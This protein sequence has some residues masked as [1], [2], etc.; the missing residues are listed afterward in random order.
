MAGPS[1][2]DIGVSMRRW[3]RQVSDGSKLS[4]QLFS[5]GSGRMVGALAVAA[6]Y[7]IAAHRLSVTEYATFALLQALAGM[8]LVGTDLGTTTMLAD[9][10]AHDRRR[11]RCALRRVIGMRLPLVAPVWLVVAGGLLV[12]A[13]GS[14]ASTIE[15]AALFLPVMVSSVV[16]SSAEGVLRALGRAWV[17]GVET[18]VLRLV[19]LV[20]S[21]IWLQHG[22]GL[23]ALVLAS[24]AVG[25]VGATGVTFAAAASAPSDG[26]PVPAGLV[27]LRRGR[28]LT[29]A[30]LVGTVYDR[31]DTWLLA[32]MAAPLA[33]STY[34]SAYRVFGAVLL[35][36]NAVAALSVPSTAGQQ[37]EALVRAGRRLV[38]WALVVTV[39]AAVVV[40]AEAPEV[41]RLLFGT[42][43]AGGAGAL[44]VLMLAVVPSAVGAAIVP[45]AVLLDGRRITTYF[46][47]SLVANVALDVAA[48]PF[49]GALGAAIGTATC[50]GAMSVAVWR[51]YRRAARRTA[52][53][54]T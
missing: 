22:G 4:H 24:G 16:I 18:M 33:V 54:G 44:R 47:V 14:A 38:A 10:V 49:L 27:T 11:A 8:F 29:A 17:E 51:R 19:Q 30:A 26:V 52:A 53:S 23:D 15:T 35:V 50:Q 1:T 6:V 7:V 12:G 40:L 37:G 46:A 45:R 20:V 31:L 43:F 39:P 13:H 48:I 9:A 25:V 5:L 34:A 28:W 3:G 21:W 42:R 32:L 2:L 41:L 36:A